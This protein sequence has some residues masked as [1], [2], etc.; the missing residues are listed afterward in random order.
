MLFTLLPRARLPYRP[1]PLPVLPHLPVWVLHLHAFYLHYIY[2][3]HV[4][5]NVT[6]PPAYHTL[7]TYLYRFVYPFITFTLRLFAVP[8]FYVYLVGSFTVALPRRLRTFVTRTPFVLPLRHDLQFCRFFT[9]RTRGSPCLHFPWVYGST[10]VGTRTPHAAHRCCLV[11]DVTSSPFTHSGYYHPPAHAAHCRGWVSSFATHVYTRHTQH[12]Y[13]H[14]YRLQCGFAVR[15]PLPQFASRFVY[16]ASRCYV[17][18][19]PLRCPL[20][21]LRFS[22]LLIPVCYRTTFILPP[23]PVCPTLLYPLPFGWLADMP[24]A[25]PHQRRCCH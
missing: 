6:A 14:R 19:R 4:L 1:L 16:V 23:P 22:A 9:P 3:L 17:R 18:G 13:H 21:L 2:T 12:R 15:M 7:P 5:P 11:Q 24:H 25:W 20:W 8:G 10:V